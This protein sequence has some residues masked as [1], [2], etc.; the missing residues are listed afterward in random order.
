MP[1]RVD[2]NDHVRT[3]VDCPQIVVFVVTN[4]MRVRPGVEALADFADE[5]ARLV[6]EEHLR[7][8]GAV[9][10]PAGAV[11]AGVNRDLTL[12]VDSD[13]GHL[14]EVHVGRKLQKI[15][16]AVERNLRHRLLSKRRWTQRDERRYKPFLHGSP[17]S[18]RPCLMNWGEQYI[19]GANGTDL[20]LL[21]QFPTAVR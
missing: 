10:R 5:L 6:E 17:P 9:G 1:F 13:A 7:R 11:R 16:I 12:G 15:G 3:L 8:S 14:A 4:R 2:A 18:Q 19:I 20:V 21:P